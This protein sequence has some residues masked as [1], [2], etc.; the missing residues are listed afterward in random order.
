MSVAAPP[1]PVQSP[2][3]DDAGSTP[4]RQL[5]CDEYELG[6]NVRV[7]GHGR[8]GPVVRARH[9][10][11]K[12][13]V[14]VKVFDA[15]AV[16]RSGS[17]GSK[18]P[19]LIEARLSCARAFATEVRA[20]QRLSWDEH[21][22]VTDEPPAQQQHGDTE[23][24]GTDADESWL[25]ALPACP[26]AV[27][28][29]LAYSH[30]GAMRPTSATDGCCYLV[31]ELGEF[32]AG[33]MAEA[34]RPEAEGRE[35]MRALLTTLSELHRAGLVLSTVSPSHFMR[36]A[37]GRWKCVAPTELRPVGHPSAPLK[38]AAAG[39]TPPSQ[40]CYMAP[41]HAAALLGGAETVPLLPS[42]DVWAVSLLGIE[43]CTRGVRLTAGAYRRRTSAADR[44]SPTAPPVRAS[45]GTNRRRSSASRDASHAPTSAKASSPS[46][47]SLGAFFRWLA[48]DGHGSLPL[49]SACAESGV[50]SGVV[51]LARAALR[52][53]PSHRPTADAILDHPYL[54]TDP[55]SAASTLEDIPVARPVQRPPRG[56]PPH[57]RPK[58]SASPLQADAT[59][60]SPTS[61]RSRT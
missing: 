29:L 30:D 15:A 14:A 20:L 32:T 51:A 18:A 37:D 36:F 61:P 34:R 17:L 55:M 43:L 11:T 31:L 13:L 3:A 44:R 5:I 24:C 4:H 60:P 27:A 59:K 7:L 56:A 38:Q 45:G 1:P 57:V 53:D 8:W 25:A 21:T 19:T 39:L 54:S 28:K 41:E 2:M 52:R 9:V 42:S 48:D 6:E 35:A 26:S 12:A 16:H 46:P 33:Q 47:H 58:P 23:L 49:P 22:T 10:Q 50:S 40:A